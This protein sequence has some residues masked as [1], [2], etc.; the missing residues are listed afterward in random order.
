MAAPLGAQE[1]KAFMELNINVIHINYSAKAEKLW[2][3]VAQFCGKATLA[4]WQNRGS[5]IC[6][7]LRPEIWRVNPLAGQNNHTKQ[8]F[9]IFFH[10]LSLVWLPFVIFHLNSYGMDLCESFALCI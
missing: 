5:G 2:C 9:D 7:F 1:A 10:A 6:W 4:N 3:E 8:R